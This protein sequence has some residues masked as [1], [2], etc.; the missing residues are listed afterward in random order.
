VEISRAPRSPISSVSLAVTCGSFINL[1]HSISH[2][3]RHGSEPLVSPCANKG[4]E[5]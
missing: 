5:G 1:S 3:T 4:Q 2:V